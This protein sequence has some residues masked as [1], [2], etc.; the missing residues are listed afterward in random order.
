MPLCYNV[1]LVIF[2]RFQSL[3]Q[4]LRSNSLII[5][6][7]NLWQNLDFCEFATI[8]YMDMNGFMVIRIKEKSYSKY[9]KQ[10]RHF[11]KLLIIST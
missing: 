9:D 1:V 3:F 5:D 4:Y 10:C 2:N 8:S 7:L 11:V 6:S